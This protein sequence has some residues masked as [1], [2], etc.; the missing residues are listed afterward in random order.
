MRQGNILALAAFGLLMA[1]PAIAQQP[2][3][4]STPNGT[5]VLR[6]TTPANAGSRQPPPG[7]SNPVSTGPAP[8]TAPTQSYEWDHSGFDRRFDRSGI[9]PQ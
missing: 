2:G 4:E 6:G 9:T 1:T 3:P 7:P 5:M 8:Q